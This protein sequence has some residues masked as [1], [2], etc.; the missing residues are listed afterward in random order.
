MDQLLYN[1]FGIGMGGKAGKRGYLTLS[2]N[3]ISSKINEITYEV[4]TNT[5]NTADEGNTGSLPGISAN[6]N[7]LLFKLL[8]GF[9]L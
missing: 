9:C 5:S 7:G 4:V 8:F 3:Y 6:Y 2:L 1:S